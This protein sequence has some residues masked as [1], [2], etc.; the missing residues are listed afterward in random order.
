MP[1]E[2]QRHERR[3]ARKGEERGD[4]EERED[5][6]DKEDRDEKAKKYD[7]VP[8]LKGAFD[9]A[10]EEDGWASLSM[11]GFYLR[12]LDPGFD[13]RTYGFKQVSQLIKS[14]SDLFEMKFQD[15]KGR[16]N[17]FIRLKEGKD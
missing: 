10:V 6:E 2:K 11:I 5:R 4:R 8:L 12:Q 15:E 16:T 1:K 14:Y 3:A 13:P 17:V 9:M 7:P